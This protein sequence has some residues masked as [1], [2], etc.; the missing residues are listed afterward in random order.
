VA[1]APLGECLSV[2]LD[3]ECARMLEPRVVRR[4]VTPFE[5]QQLAAEGFDAGDLAVT[6]FAAKEAVY[7]AQFPLTRRFLDF[8]E[9]RIHLNSP[10]GTFAATVIPAA[11]DEPAGAAVF[12]GRFC[13]TA[14]FVAAAVEIPAPASHVDRLPHF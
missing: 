5:W 12:A 9:V 13:H 1:V 11:G 14:E 4:V 6:L 3:V 2:G 10:E 8:P 7:K